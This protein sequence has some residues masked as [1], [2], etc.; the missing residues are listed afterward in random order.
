MACHMCGCTR[1]FWKDPD[2]EY[3]VYAFDLKGR[4]VVFDE[5]DSFDAPGIDDERETFCDHCAWHG[6]LKEIKG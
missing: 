6:K 1:F 3:E 5:E 2:D 4:E